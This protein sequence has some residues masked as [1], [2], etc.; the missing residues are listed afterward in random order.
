MRTNPQLR[1]RSPAAAPALTL[2]RPYTYAGRRTRARGS[3]TEQTHSMRPTV[4][5]PGTVAVSPARR[6][7]PASAT[8]IY[9]SAVGAQSLDELRRR[10]PTD[11]RHHTTGSDQ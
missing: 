1:A 6:F 5:Q 7:D 8:T 11:F 9:E 10:P 2:A 4:R 3:Q